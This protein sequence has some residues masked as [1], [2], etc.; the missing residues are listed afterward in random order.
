MGSW[1]GLVMLSTLATIV[2]PAELQITAA[3][4]EADSRALL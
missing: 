1:P 2:S 3:E 4:P